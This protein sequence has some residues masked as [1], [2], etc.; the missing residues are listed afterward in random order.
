[1]T[2]QSRSTNFLATATLGDVLTWAADRGE[3]RDAVFELKKVPARMGMADDD[4]G[5]IPADL[6]H[7]DKIVSPTPYGPVSKSKDVAAARRRGNS[8]VRALLERFQAAHGSAKPSGTAASYD[9]VIEGVKSREGFPDAGAVFPTSQ[10]KALFALRS[11][12]RVPL[13]ALDQP[14]VDRVF[15]EATTEKRKS[16]RRAIALVN[17]LLRGHNRWPELLPHL[18]PA[19]LVMPRSSDRAERIVWATL[20]QVFRAEAESV[21]REV[22]LA[23]ADLAAWIKLQTA[24][25]LTS[26]EINRLV[27][28]RVAGRGRRPK[29]SRTAIAG[30]RGAVTWLVRRH[31]QMT[32]SFADLPSLS[33]LMTRDLITSAIDDQIRRSDASPLL[34]D[35]A[36]SQT[37]ANR[38]TNLRTVARHGLHDPEIV[39]HLDLLRVAYHEYVVTPKEMTEEADHTCRMLQIRPDLAARFVNAPAELARVAE[40]AISEAK[41]AGDRDA[42]ELGLRLFAAAVLFAV[43]VSRPL[44]TSNLIALRHRGCEMISGNLTWIKKKQHAELS[45]LK[46]EIKNDRTVTVHVVGP[47]AQILWDWMQIHRKRFLELREL[48]DTPYVFPGEAQPRNVKDAIALPAGC[49]APATMAELWAL[50][51]ERIGLGITPHACRHAIATL[52]L[53]VEPGNFAKAAAVLGD[54]EATVRRHYGRDSGEQAAKAVRVSLLARHPDIFKRMKGKAA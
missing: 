24:G 25:G 1:M 17:E 12:C 31:K 38:L 35:A 48:E 16:L 26:E 32:G 11:R 40:T 8:R 18:P 29:N 50:G 46:G 21:F 41:A 44:R 53:A 7:F 42:E 5:L 30:Y 3:S 39:A 34:K 4:I 47:D 28:E 43:Q 27:T 36:K 20:P 9:A 2:H 19:S 33:A 49:M 14:E 6:S 45:F 10:H 23:P 37:L 54:G 22:L 52:I 51:D 13:R 15:E